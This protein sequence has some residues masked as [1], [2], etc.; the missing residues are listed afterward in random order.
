MVSY[1]EKVKALSVEI[2]N[3]SKSKDEAKLRGQEKDKYK[4]LARRLKEERNQYKEAIQEK[5]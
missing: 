5:M 3:L 4:T 2:A 1:D